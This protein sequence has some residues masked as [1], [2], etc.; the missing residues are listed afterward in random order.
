MSK[1]DFEEN[2]RPLIASKIIDEGHQ[3]EEVLPP[4]SSLGSQKEKKLQNLREIIKKRNER[5]EA[6]EKRA[7]GKEFYLRK[8]TNFLFT[9]FFLNLA[10]EQI[11][12]YAL[13][14]DYVNGYMDNKTTVFWESM[15]GNNFTFLMFFICRLLGYLVSKE[16]LIKQI[17]KDVFRFYIGRS[18]PKSHHFGSSS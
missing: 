13:L 1:A 5:K 6:K 18:W 9:S 7:S 16:F 17:E 8:V 10:I 2:I 3:D 14:H 4:T 11:Y 15:E 12:S